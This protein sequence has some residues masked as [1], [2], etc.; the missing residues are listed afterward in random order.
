MNK[1]GFLT[2]FLPLIEESNVA[3]R[4][5]DT[6]SD[7][8]LLD[9]FTAAVYLLVD[10]YPEWDLTSYSRILE[11]NGITSVSEA[12]VDGLDAQCIGALLVGAVR[13]ERF[14]DGALKGYLE[15]GSITR[16]LQR[17][18]KIDEETEG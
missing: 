5:A 16:W 13:A 17:L 2:R 15:D 10:E 18:K 4:N 11:Q 8:V 6:K 12:A 7:R 14:C 1:F 3:C 9:R